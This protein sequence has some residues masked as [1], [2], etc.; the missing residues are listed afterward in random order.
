MITSSQFVLTSRYSTTC[1]RKAPLISNGANATSL[2]K[3][4]APGIRSSKL[5]L[6]ARISRL[7]IYLP[8]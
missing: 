7:I 1:Q 3:T 4:T 8:G 6:R 5:N 2:E